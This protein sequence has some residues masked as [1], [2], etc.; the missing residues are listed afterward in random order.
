LDSA[1]F[2]VLEYVVWRHHF[3]MNLDYSRISRE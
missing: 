1:T 3:K 2:D